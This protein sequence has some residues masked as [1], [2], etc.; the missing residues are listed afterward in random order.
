VTDGGEAGPGDDTIYVS[1]DV[2]GITSNG[3]LAIIDTTTFDLTNIA[4][5]SP[6]PG[7]AGAELTGTGDGRLFAFSPSDTPG[8]S[9]LAQID[10]VTAEIVAKDPLPGVTQGGAWA[11]GFWGGD[12]YLFTG[13]GGGSEVH[14]FDPKS[15]KDKIVAKLTTDTIVGAG[16]ST[17]APL[18]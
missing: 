15:G 10:P 9:F 6:A 16:V 7:A 13:A 1:R 8:A 3:E 5:F 18:D 17:C 11:F 12:F 2:G 4:Y 14:R